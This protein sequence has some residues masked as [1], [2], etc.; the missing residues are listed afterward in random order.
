V[1]AMF[2]SVQSD[3]KKAKRDALASSFRPSLRRVP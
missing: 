2:A 3:V 1:I